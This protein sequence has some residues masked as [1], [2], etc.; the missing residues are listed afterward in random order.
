M[1]SLSGVDAMFLNVIQPGIAKEMIADFKD[2]HYSI[3]FLP[4]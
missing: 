3:S 1:V 4:L 2:L